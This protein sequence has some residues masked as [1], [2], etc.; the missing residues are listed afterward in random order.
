MA[1]VSAQ[2]P[3]SGATEPL[4]GLFSLRDVF[5]QGFY[6]IRIVLACVL[7]GLALGIVGALL[8]PPQFTAD[9]SLLVLPDPTPTTSPGRS[10][11]A[12][13]AAAARLAA[14]LAT[15]V[16]QSWPSSNATS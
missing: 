14:S 15:G 8:S 5:V 10:R 13:C 4:S 6:N 9:S 11:S 16:G 2:T 3:A 1:L 7:A 12:I